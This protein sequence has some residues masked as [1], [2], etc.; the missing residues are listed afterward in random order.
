MFKIKMIGS[1]GLDVTPFMVQD[2]INE[3]AGQDLEIDLSSVGGT[4]GSGLE[5]AD[6]FK[7][8]KKNFPKAQMILNIK[9]QAS[10][11]ASH[12]A[13]IPVFDIVTVEETT[14][15]MR[16]NPQ[17]MV[18]GDHNEMTAAADYMRRYANV[19][20]I[21][22]AR[23]ANMSLEQSKE[24]MNNTVYLFGKEIVAAGF[25]DEVVKGGKKVMKDDAIAIMKTN[26]ETC[27][28]KIKDE[29]QDDTELKKAYAMMK[30]IEIPEIE[31]E[32]E[33]AKQPAL[34]GKNN[35]EEKSI[36]NIDEL[37][38]E[39]PEI[40]AEAML[41]GVDQEK[42]RVNSLLE[43]KSK[44]D[45]E[46]IPEI[47]DRI[48]EGIKNGETINAVEIGV[49]AILKTPGTMAA[50]ESP[51]D[52]DT[53]EDLSTSGEIQTDDVKSKIKKNSTF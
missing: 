49:M 13:A 36:M 15:H 47:S 39:H 28:K 29:K 45:F 18:I 48:E 6:M 41:A 1:I 51:G 30:K 20:A 53:G 8:Y 34:S 16:H 5:M 23:K 42:E 40:H 31:T 27:M 37:K 32:L 19:M 10:S 43:M 46:G 2:Q 52:I 50:V 7:D 4:I 12:F 22:Y 35:Q 21:E 25:A 11:M 38:K 14:L 3:A 33:P 17:G 24:D 26:F 44:K 9:A